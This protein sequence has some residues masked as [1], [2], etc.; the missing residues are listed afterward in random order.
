MFWAGT[1]EGTF[2][3]VSRV[4]PPDSG[5]ISQLPAFE[6]R[7]VPLRDASVLPFPEPRLEETDFREDASGCVR[8]LR[9]ALAIEAVAAVMIYGLWQLSHLAH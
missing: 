2:D 4:F 9:F 6:L 1:E 3:M 7:F 8:G 5:A